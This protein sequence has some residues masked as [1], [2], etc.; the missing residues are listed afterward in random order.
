MSH[1]SFASINQYLRVGLL[2][3]FIY[4]GME[5]LLPLVWPF[6]IGAFLAKCLYPITCK[7]HRRTS[8]PMGV[9]SLAL[10]GGL[11][12]IIGILIVLLGGHILGHIQDLAW[13]G[14]WVEAEVA[15]LV[16]SCMEQVEALWGVERQQ[17]EIFVMNHVNVAIDHIQVN[18]VPHVMEESYS[19]AKWI[20]AAIATVV[21]TVVATLLIAKD[22]E[23]MRS[24]AYAHPELR[25]LMG[26]VKKVGV[27]FRIF[28]KSQL[29][30]MGIITIIC[31]IGY[32]FIE[33]SVAIYLG[34]I[35]GLLDAIPFIG[36]GIIL[37]PLALIYVIEG[38]MLKAILSL[39]FYIISSL[40]RDYLEPKL[41]GER[42]GYLPIIIL[43][44]I[45]LGIQIYGIAGIVL[46]PISF[47]LVNEINTLIESYKNH[48]NKEES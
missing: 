18:L 41:I 12:L 25:S 35:T 13:Y 33:P 48:T 24:Y 29:I 10:V 4:L 43:L 14:N 16:D 45:Y 38:Q 5:Y 19:Y 7:L 17:I 9:I 31:T 36:T 30:I 37:I 21:V 44:T 32:C 47:M 39:L 22:Y 46:G 2:F 27:V 42:L 1:F 23:V 6:L 8:I 20:F 40:V 3:L 28:L 34:I 11:V 26:V 15:Q